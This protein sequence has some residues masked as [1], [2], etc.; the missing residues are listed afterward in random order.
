MPI[1]SLKARGSRLSRGDV[2]ADE[3]GEEYYSYDY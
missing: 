1:G 3:P 2:L